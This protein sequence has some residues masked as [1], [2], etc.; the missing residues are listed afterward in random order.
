ML[1][2]DFLVGEVFADTGIDLVQD[3]E[4]DGAL[5]VDFDISG[6]LDGAF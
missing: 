1:L 5:V 3:P 2:E 6:C 4:L